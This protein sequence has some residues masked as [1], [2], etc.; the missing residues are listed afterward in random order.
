[1][2]IDLSALAVELPGYTDMVAVRSGGQAHVVRAR[3][4]SDDRDVA[5]KIVDVN[6]N[7][8]DRLERELEALRGVTSDHLPALE[9]PDLVDVTLN[10][11]PHAILIEE[12]I[13]G[14]NVEALVGASWEEADALLLAHDVVAALQAVA[15]R[16]LIHRDV[17]PLNIIRR[18]SGNPGRFVLLD[19]GIARHQTLSSL[20]T[21][22][23]HPGSPRYWS[24]DQLRARDDRALD[25]RS[26]LF[27]VG[28]I[29]F[30]ALT[31]AHPYAD[32]GTPNQT[33]ALRVLRNQR[34][35]LSA[36]R[37]DLAAGTRAVVAR[38]L[39]PFAHQRYRDLESAKAA[40]HAAMDDDGGRRCSCS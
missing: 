17:K 26:D 4:I 35:T 20:T 31:G 39:Q 9:A 21:P 40:I 24:P 25:P 38:L 2:A 7:G 8:R 5:L 32:A 36:Y 27:N 29:L 6:A 37:S 12:F 1:M 13:D 10:G 3:R 33:Y 11:R 23:L 34:R 14:D 22:G 19:L 16:G 30:Q 18:A 15:P 28:L